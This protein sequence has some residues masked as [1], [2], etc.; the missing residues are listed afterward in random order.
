MA[1]AERSAKLV[2]VEAGPPSS[3]DSLKDRDERGAAGRGRA[4][5]RLLWVLGAALA[6]CGALLAAQLERAGRLAKEADS[7]RSELQ[8]SREMIEAYGQ[9]M[10]AVR[11]RLQEL[12]TGVEDLQTLVAGEPSP[13][14]E[15][16]SEP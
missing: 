1:E 5:N 11:G 12:A 7:L 8:I 4:G 6:L 15:T 2:P 14:A 3:R 10:E 9:R 13:E 16:L